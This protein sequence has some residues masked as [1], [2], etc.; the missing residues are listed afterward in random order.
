M[1]FRKRRLALGTSQGIPPAS[2]S[3]AEKGIVPLLTDNSLVVNSKWN[4]PCVL[5]ENG[6]YT[7]WAS[8]G[9]GFSGDISIYRLRSNDKLN[10][11]LAPGTP[12]LVRGA[13]GSTDARAVETP[14]VVYFQGQYHMFYTGYPFD[15]QDSKS[16]RILHATSQD[17]IAWAKD[18]V[19][20]MGPNDPNNATP[21]LT[22]NQYVVGEPGAV[23]YQGVLV[24][25][26]AAIG[27]DIGV[28]TMLET[29]GMTYSTDGVNWQPDRQV[30]RPDQA[31]Y[32]R[33]S[34]YG[35]ST[36]AAVVVG[37]SVMV[38]YSIVQASPFRMIGIGTSISGNGAD[39]WSLNPIPTLANDL[40][41]RSS[42]IQ[43]PAMLRDATGTDMWFGGNDGVHLSIGYMR[44][45]P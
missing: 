45:T 34:Y 35:F 1:F 10:W 39:N 22:Y 3:D 8:C 18:P 17:G 13:P 16:Y 6:G 31:V 26:F 29:I 14:S 30:I 32:P 24:L 12:V 7:M 44:F 41:W 27:A 36:P 11:I 38:G 20:I 15:G 19:F 33:G 40:P 43:S 5:A 21:N 4:D 37:T 25:Y 23:V 42:E 9:D 28:G 2:V